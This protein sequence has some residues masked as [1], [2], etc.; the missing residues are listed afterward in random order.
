MKVLFLAFALL[1]STASAGSYLFI[2]AGGVTPPT[3]ILLD[4]FVDVNGTLLAAH[5]MDVGPGWLKKSTDAEIQS[6][7]MSGKSG[8][9]DPLY[10]SSAGVSAGT[11]TANI[12]LNVSDTQ[13]NFYVGTSVSASA[14]VGY[15]VIGYPIAGIVQFYQGGVVAQVTG[16]TFSAGAQVWKAVLTTTDLTFYIDGVSILTSPITAATDVYWGFEMFHPAGTASTV[17]SQFKVTS[18]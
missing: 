6:N 16:L 7:T 4:N 18:P 2:N 10:I 17:W 11:V 3:T 8:S 5:T 9:T 13:V 15:I 14:S 1:V 12:N